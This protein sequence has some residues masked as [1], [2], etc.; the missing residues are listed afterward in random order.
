MWMPSNDEIKHI[1]QYALMNFWGVRSNGVLDGKTMDGFAN[2]L[3][4]VLLKNGV[5]ETEIIFGRS[6]KLPGYFRMSKDWDMIVLKNLQDGTRRLL[7]VIE[8]K[9]MHGSVGNNLNNRSEEAVGSSYDLWKAF[10]H[11]AFGAS[12]PFLGYIYVMTDHPANK[13][14][15]ERRGNMLFRPL[16]EYTKFPRTQQPANYEERAELF[17]MKMVQ[18]QLY[19]KCALIIADTKKLGDY[20]TPNEELSIE[21]L[22][23]SLVGHIIA[24]QTS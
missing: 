7:A 11:G 21:L 23:R 12:R 18:E 1:T 19:D 13:K 5:H 24:H 14:G 15:T 22:I 4:D 17:M 3:M 16:D 9:S 8:F 6:A 10:E 20:R 2:V